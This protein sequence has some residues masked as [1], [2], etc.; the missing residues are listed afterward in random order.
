MAM[1]DLRITFGE[2]PG[3]SR[4]VN[5]VR[6]GFVQLCVAAI[7]ILYVGC[8]FDPGGYYSYLHFSCSYMILLCLVVANHVFDCVALAYCLWSVL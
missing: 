8:L 6:F 4:F 2:L 7:D 5:L 3:I 1:S